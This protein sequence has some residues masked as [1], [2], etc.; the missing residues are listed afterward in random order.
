MNP[1]LFIINA[2]EL[3]I[4]SVCLDDLKVKNIIIKM[5]NQTLVETCNICQLPIGIT[6]KD[7]FRN[8]S[9]CK[10]YECF[11]C[12]G[13]ETLMCNKPNNLLTP[14][15]FNFCNDIEL[16]KKIKYERRI[17]LF[18]NEKKSRYL[19]CFPKKSIN[20]RCKFNWIMSEIEFLQILDKLNKS[21]IN[22]NHI[23]LN[24]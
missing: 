13:D 15:E 11:E 1:S 21:E 7:L 17:F 22:S 23:D 9:L 18:D 16:I 20:G 2:F 6:A 4:N 14:C 19:G 10:Y 8:K 5:S 3:K 12:I 24:L